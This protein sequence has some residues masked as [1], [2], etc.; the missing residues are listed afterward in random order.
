MAVPY[1]RDSEYTPISRPTERK[2]HPLRIPRALEKRLPFKSKSKL[3]SKRKSNKPTL[4]QRRCV[5]LCV[6]VCVSVCVCM[7]MC[8]LYVSECVCV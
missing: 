4:E 2:F 7:C 6:C 5:I 3:M 1:N 8:T